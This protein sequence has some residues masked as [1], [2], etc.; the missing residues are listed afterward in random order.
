MKGH[1]NLAAAQVNTGDL[2]AAEQSYT[3]IIIA[4]EAVDPHYNLGNLYWQQERYDEALAAHAKTV[5]LDPSDNDAL[6]NLAITHIALNDADLALPFLSSSFACR[7]TSVW[8]ELWA[9]VCYKWT[10]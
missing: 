7:I 1:I 5:E 4:P 10:D 6:Y 9:D 2:E 3:V 8:R